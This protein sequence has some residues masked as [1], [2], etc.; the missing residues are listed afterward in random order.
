V[1]EFRAIRIERSRLQGAAAPVPAAERAEMAVASYCHPNP[2]IRWLF[3][4]RLDTALAF[5]RVGAGERVL[6][7]G[8]GTGILLPSLVAAGARVAATD[9]ELRPA[10]TLVAE[11]ALD[12]E[13]VPAAEQPAWLAAHPVAVDCI[14]ALDVLEH[15]DEP[16]LGPLCE[17]FR[18]VLSPAGR[19]VVS[20]PTESLA[21][22]IGRFVAGFKGEYHHHTVFDLDRLLVRGGWRPEARRREP[23]WPLPRAFLVTRYTPR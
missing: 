1:S 7:F 11:R 10:R 6:D 19:L 21:Y 9:V 8:T 20:G 4:R 18:E 22:A 14:F 17:R 5:A 13:I 2:A 16:E 3:W 12:V 15:L 23:P